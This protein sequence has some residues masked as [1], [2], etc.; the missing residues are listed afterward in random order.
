MLSTCSHFLY[1]FTINISVDLL[2]YLLIYLQ[3]IH[4]KHSTSTSDRFIGGAQRAEFRGGGELG[5]CEDIHGLNSSGG[6]ARS[7]MGC[8]CHHEEGAQGTADPAPGA[9]RTG[10]EDA[11]HP[12]CAQRCFGSKRR[13]QTDALVRALSSN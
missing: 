4:R 1:C 12:I 6:H 10:E 11:A 7:G 5:A 13:K 2:F 9:T 3:R 8:V